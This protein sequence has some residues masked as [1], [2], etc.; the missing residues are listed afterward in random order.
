M[1]ELFNASDSSM[2]PSALVWPKRSGIDQSKVSSPA[3]EISTRSATSFQPIAT[4][5]IATKP[6][7]TTRWRVLPESLIAASDSRR[8]RRRLHGDAERLVVVEGLEHEA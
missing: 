1:Y 6:T 2:M 3:A 5:M 7:A 4:A 8:G